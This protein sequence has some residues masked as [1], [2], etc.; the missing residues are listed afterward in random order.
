MTLSAKLQ[1]VI[2]GDG[3][4]LPAR[5]SYT[6]EERS[7]VHAQKSRL[8][9]R[10]KKGSDWDGEA[11][12]DNI[13]WPLATSLIREGNVELLKAAMYYR[14]MHDSAKSNAMLGGTSV[15]MDDG[16]SID[17]YS[18]IRDDG[19]IAY[20]RT[21]KSTAANVDIPARRR[22]DASTAEDGDGPQKNWSSIPKPWNGDHPVN[23]KLDAQQRLIQLRGKLG[24]LAEPFE[25]AVVDGNT[26]EAVGN[27]LG[28][29]HKVPATAA[30]RTAVHMGL[31]TIRD[32][33]GN[34]SREDLA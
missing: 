25:L 32:A 29:A 2:S 34:V 23:S 31:I 8:A 22:F 11:A 4:N 19:K 33:I 30:G 21:R 9:L 5:T 16:F 7:G 28:H 15:R 14:K 6:E 24:I 1:A 26:Y 18:V 27:S 13:A 20:R 10:A 17:R 3:S 12:N